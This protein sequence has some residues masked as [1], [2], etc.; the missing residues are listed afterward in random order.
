MSDHSIPKSPAKPVWTKPKLEVLTNLAEA[1]AN[2][3][4]AYPSEDNFG[5]FTVDGY[6][7]IGPTS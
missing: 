5:T 4:L 1:G 2:S 7:G 3:K 6:P